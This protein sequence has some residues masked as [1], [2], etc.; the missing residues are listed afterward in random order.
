[1]KMDCLNNYVN[2]YKNPIILSNPITQVASLPYTLYLSS[3]GKYFVG[4]AEELEFE[5]NRGAWAGLINPSCSGVNLFVYVWTV[6]TYGTSTTKAE[7]WINSDPC[8]YQ[9]ISE[10]V[11]STNTTLCPLP[12]PKVKLL[13]ASN[14]KE[15]F[16][17]GVKAYIRAI[18]N[19]VTVADEEDGKFIIPPGG[20]F[21]I[22][23]S[24]PEFCNKP[25]KATMA[26][27][28]AEEKID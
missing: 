20:S 3:Q 12:K 23:L 15:D 25:T 22:L 1:M 8:G 4:H 16:K 27:G 10:S 18:P 6:T 19:E 7:V 28:W 21:I 24:N 2:N 26:F 14:V 13:S 17:N 5:N 9:D 11:T